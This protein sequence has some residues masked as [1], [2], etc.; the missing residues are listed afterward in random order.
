M[1]RILCILVI[2]GCS[3]H[4]EID[5]TILVGKWKLIE[6]LADPGDGSGTYQPVKGNYFIDFLTDGTFIANEAMCYK[7]QIINQ[8]SS[9]TYDS[10]KLTLSFNNCPS[11]VISYRSPKTIFSFIHHVLKLADQSI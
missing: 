7:D 6:S 11:F 1:K 4:E 9:G 2:I 10:V 8:P 3:P 5:S